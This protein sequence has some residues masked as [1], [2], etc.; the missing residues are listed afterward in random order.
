MLQ[1]PELATREHIL[2]WLSGKPAAKAYTWLDSNCCPAGL[3]AEECLG[4]E[5]NGGWGGIPVLSHDIVGGTP[6]LLSLSTLARAKPRTFGAL[7][8]RARAAWR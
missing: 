7:Y 6:E 4:M 1:R 3:Y 2:M 5:R 8:A